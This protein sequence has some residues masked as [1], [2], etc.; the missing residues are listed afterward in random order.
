MQETRQAVRVETT[1]IAECLDRLSSKKAQNLPLSTYRLQL[2]AGFRFEDARKLLP[3]L[4]Q[5][6]FTHCYF[7]PILKARPGSM[8][9]YDITD[10][11][12]LN[13]EIGTEEDLN[14]FVSEM[15]SMGMGLILDIVPNHMGI[16]Y[17][18][19]PWW[20]DVLENGEASEYANYFDIDW[21]PFKPE[22]GG[23]VLLPIL[24][25]T[26][27][28]ELE[29][30]NLKLEYGDGRFRV[31]YYDKQLPIDPQTYPL[32]FEE[33][34]QLREFSSD[35]EWQSRGAAE[36]NKLVGDFRALP[37]HTTKDPA[38]IRQRRR[39]API[40]QNRLMELQRRYDGASAV[41]AAA[42]QRLN[43]IPDVARSFGPLHRLLE[44]Q[45][46]RLAFWR[47]SSEEI[48]YRRFFDINDLVGLRMENPA[49]FSA[50]HKLIRKLLAQGAVTGLRIDHPDGLLQPI[51][52][53]TRLQMLYASS[54]CSGMEA[55]PPLAEN[56]IEEEIVRRFGE[57]D[58]ISQR[59]PLYVLVEKI[60]EPGE[61]LP[62]EWPIDGTVGYDFGNV[63]NNVFIQ[64]K[65]QR[66]FTNLYHRIIGGAVDVDTLIYNSKK[67]IMETSLAS[68]VTV[69]TQMLQQI[70][71][72]DR[73]ARDFTLNALVRAIRE[74]IACFPVYRTYIDA[75]GNISERDAGYITEAIVR[76]KR[77]NRTGLAAIFDF[78]RSV[79]L[80][81]AGGEY[82]PSDQ[83]RARLGFTLKLQQVTGPVMAKGLE[84]TTCYVYNR[85][86][87]VNEV[88]GSPTEFGITLNEFHED[89]RNRVREWP[90]SMLGTSTHDSK[91]SEDVRARLNVLS[92]IPKE[93]ASQVFRWRRANKPKSRLLGDGRIAPDAN[94]EYFLYQTLVG[95]W[96]LLMETDGEREEFVARIQNYMIKALNEAKVNMS[97]TSPNPEYQQAVESFIKKVL[98]PHSR[99][100]FFWDSIQ[101]F[102]PRVM[103]FGALNSLSQ[104]VL[105]LTVPGVPDVY[106]GCELWDFSLVDPDNRRPGD[107]DLRRQMMSD[108]RVAEGSSSI[109][110]FCGELL[111]QWK[112][113]RVK[114]WTAM[115]ILRFRRD[116]PEL[117]QQGTYDPL[118]TG[119]E[120]D[121]HVVAFVR[122]RQEQEVVVVVP[123]FIYTLMKGDP[124]A[125]IG[126]QVWRESAIA[127]GEKK[128]HWKNVLTGELVQ[129]RDSKLLCR[130]VFASFPV[131]VLASR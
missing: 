21:D 99:G 10:H 77:R 9:G 102:L 51:Q 92:E 43:G 124:R 78:L 36:F 95:A 86:I 44:A 61:K 70:C 52:Y 119:D 98:S 83:Y 106:R 22:L 28:D 45:A 131:A 62:Q 113:G 120:R 127:I 4:H 50:T 80:L 111:E 56:G 30:G 64:T 107:Y 87:S 114:M 63:L 118:S 40:L 112:D 54:Q 35:R 6:G 26:Y 109:P 41:I 66:A 53:F 58:W 60:L 110:Q 71:A 85:F 20:L 34:G 15:K 88:G 108:L 1:E 17:G 16:G 117:F 39:E 5:F 49:V 123:R 130:E 23:K 24:G 19:T 91:R 116:S 59:A 67:L 32:I 115:R 75:R 8:H 90:S 68:E 89:N 33:L 93:W 72:A 81:E 13:P 38:Q 46:Y 97:W 31:L 57:H 65:N 76:A 73:R 129:A 100:R 121:Q 47:V 125:P 105:K 18:T 25:E 12:A 101:R 27:G 69:L 94:E 11:N 42:L 128:Q 126:E 2:N 48:N 104:L 96:P 29:K 7:S 84:D 79:L 82:I 122:R 3:Y 14:R 55:T 74:V 37:L 103:Y